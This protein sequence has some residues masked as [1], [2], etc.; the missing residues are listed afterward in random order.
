MRVK[1]ITALGFLAVASQANAALVV[2]STDSFGLSCA[3]GYTTDPA[4]YK[5]GVTY[6]GDGYFQ[7]YFDRFRN[8][9]VHYLKDNVT[10]EFSLGKL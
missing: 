2:Y 1:I 8:P 6:R 9:D 7:T 10:G 5:F 4:G 3:D